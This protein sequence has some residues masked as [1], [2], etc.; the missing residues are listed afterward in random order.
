MFLSFISSPFEHL[1]FVFDDTETKTPNISITVV[2]S[3]SIK[4]ICIVC[5]AL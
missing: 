5:K 2:N 4:I 1:L 3:V